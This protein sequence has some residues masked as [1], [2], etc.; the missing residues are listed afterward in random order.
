MRDKQSSRVSIR[1]SDDQRN[2]LFELACEQGCTLSDIIRDAIE[3]YIKEIEFFDY[4]A[5]EGLNYEY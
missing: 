4:S 2:K 5:E 3:A 1:L